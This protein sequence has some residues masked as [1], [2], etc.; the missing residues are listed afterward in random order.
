MRSLER[1]ANAIAARPALASLTDA[2]LV[3]EMRLWS[4]P[5]AG[6]LRDGLQVEGVAMIIYALARRA[7]RDH[8]EALSHLATGIPGN[9][10]TQISLAIE[11][12][13][14]AATGLEAEFGST[15]SWPE[16]REALERSEAG[17]AWLT[18]LDAFLAAYGHR[19]PR[20]FDIGAGRWSEDPTMI[21]DLVRIALAATPGE[22]MRDRLDR[23]GRKREEII[24]RAVRA[25]A[26]WR[27]PA[28]RILARLVWHYM[29]LREAPKHY[30]V[31]LFQRIRNAAR[32]LGRRL[33]AR[34]VL[35]EESD[36]FFLEW[37]ELRTM[38]EGG[39]PPDSIDELIAER[40]AR[41]ERF[42]EARAPDMLRSDRVPIEE[43]ADDD[44]DEEGV[45]RGV[46]AAPGVVKGP[47]RILSEP[48]PRAMSDGDVLVV[49][50]AD[51]G[52]TPLFPRASAVVMEIGGLMCHAAVVA[53]EMG[54]PAVFGVREATR[55]LHDG[56]IVQ[57]D[58][59]AGR[60]TRTDA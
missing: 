36:V 28:M 24:G 26:P 12:L 25:A 21:V 40:K 43:D 8:P 60:V 54:L 6:E 32:E 51:P 58:G 55:L 23:L 15:N 29:P 48:D 49:E 3:G 13:G 47:V 38:A 42:G 41:L 1:G 59:V 4:T 16:L 17:R 30:G 7:F 14:G 50:Y 19:G 10:T 52:W 37:P 18:E 35:R 57:V 46:G 31:V 11:Q 53:R 27:R 45:L 20:E 34:G 5:A 39:P 22:S 44:S 9:P 2:A 56:E 33:A